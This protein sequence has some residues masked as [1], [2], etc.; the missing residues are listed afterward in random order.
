M[1]TRV[2]P[3]VCTRVPGWTVGWFQRASQN[4]PNS[5]LVALAR[6]SSIHVC[7]ALIAASLTDM[8]A[9][10]VASRGLA[11]NCKQCY[12]CSSIHQ[13]KF[14][15]WACLATSATKTASWLAFKHDLLV[16]A[17]PLRFDERCLSFRLL[18]PR[19]PE[20]W[21]T[22]CRPLR[23]SGRCM[24]EDSLGS[25]RLHQEIRRRG[26]GGSQRRTVAQ[27]HEA[28]TVGNW[29]MWTKI[30]QLRRPPHAYRVQA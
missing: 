26:F 18:L 27:R 8:H 5:P 13:T 25:R 28:V 30:L 16:S 9:H 15:A 14:T 1:S 24:G 3:I 19:P 17:C 10:I 6:D 23:P 22:R 2:Q 7:P 21:L 4:W 11:K 20:F 12:A 29:R